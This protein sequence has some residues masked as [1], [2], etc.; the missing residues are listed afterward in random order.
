MANRHFSEVHPDGLA[1]KSTRPKAGA[2]K[3]AAM[4]ERTAAWPGLP[5]KKQP[6]DRSGGVK[7]VTTHAKSE[8]V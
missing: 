5:G 6:R 3:G 8:G 2:K 4:P 1:G 7:K